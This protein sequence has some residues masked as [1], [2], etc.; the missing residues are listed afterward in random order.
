MPGRVRHSRSTHHDRFDRH[1][2]TSPFRRAFWPWPTSDRI[3]ARFA[4]LHAVGNWHEG[5]IFGTATSQSVNG[6]LAD[7]PA[8]RSAVRMTYRHQATD[9]GS[10]LTLACFL[11]GATAMTQ[12][13]DAHQR[14]TRRVC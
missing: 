8:P 5:A 14:R 7:C 3:G 13:G 10:P 2:L 9:P 12:T 6:G 4:A 1:H 11:P